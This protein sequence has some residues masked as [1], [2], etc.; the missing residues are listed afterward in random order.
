VK[1]QFRIE[2][3]G[4]EHARAVFDCG[5]PALNRYFA[6]QVGQDIRRKVATCFVAVD[7]VQ[8]TTA[9]Y[10]TLAAASV[11]LTDLPAATAKKL[12]RYPT[13]PVARM[14]RLA[15][16]LAYQGQRLG[17]ALLWDALLRALASDVAVHALVVDAKD[18]AAA[19]FY[20]HHGFIAFGGS[21]LQ[22]FLPVK[23]AKALS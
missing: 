15:V 2:H 4:D 23:T 20:R 12:P 21:P 11:A 18:E 13:V 17:A 3:L 19:S 9:A 10:Y 8:G 1:R 22:L 14:G 6:E 5:T 16:A 7:V